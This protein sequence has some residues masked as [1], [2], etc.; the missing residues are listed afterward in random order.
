[1]SSTSSDEEYFSAGEFF[2]SSQESGSSSSDSNLGLEPYQFEPVEEDG[3]SGSSS[4]SSS[5][6]TEELL[7][8][9]DD[10]HG[11]QTDWCKCGNCRAMAHAHERVCCTDVTTIA[12]KLQGKG[13]LGQVKEIISFLF[14][15]MFISYNFHQ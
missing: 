15:Y 6:E 9:M 7:Y 12:K 2:A 14:T 8:S 4:S 3:S 5:Q 10:D 13:Q 11:N 1:M